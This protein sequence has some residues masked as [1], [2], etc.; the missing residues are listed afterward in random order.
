MTIPAADHAAAPAKTVPQQVISN[1]RNRRRKDCE[2][3]IL[4]NNTYQAKKSRKGPRSVP[5][6]VRC[7]NCE[8]PWGRRATT[9][10]RLLDCPLLD[11]GWR[12]DGQV[13]LN[14]AF[15][16]PGWVQS[17]LPDGRQRVGTMAFR[18]FLHQS[19]LYQPLGHGCFCWPAGSAKGGGGNS[20]RDSG[21]APTAVIPSL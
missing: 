20:A 21:F 2:R 7:L 12:K 6:R 3:T 8:M 4:L 11:D 16:R 10:A 14:F 1:G 17:V 19:R 18:R 13:W 5:A 15:Q 9:A